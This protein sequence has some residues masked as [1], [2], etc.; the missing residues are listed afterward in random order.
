MKRVML[1]ELKAGMLFSVS[2]FKKP[3]FRLLEIGSE[4]Y[5][6]EHLNCGGQTAK[7]THQQMSQYSFYIEDIVP[8]IEQPVVSTSCNHTSTFRNHAGG[9]YFLQCSVC[10]AD[11]GNV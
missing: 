10:K 1:G 3:T 6:V 2:E 4:V 7:L 5:S 9:T 8:A 11:L